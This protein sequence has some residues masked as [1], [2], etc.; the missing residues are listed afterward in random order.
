MHLQ[1]KTR[2]LSA[3]RSWNPSKW[4]AQSRVCSL[5]HVSVKH[6]TEEEEKSLFRLISNASSSVL[7][8]SE[9]TLEKKI[10]DGAAGTL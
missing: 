9:R 3:R 6:K 5:S 10:P 4:S 2:C 8:L 7:L 1:D